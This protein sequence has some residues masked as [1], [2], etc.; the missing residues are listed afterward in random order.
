M[1]SSRL[2]WLGVV[3]LLFVSSGT[4]TLGGEPG[5]A[6]VTR[7][8]SA[9]RK[10]VIAPA[11]IRFEGALEHRLQVAA[12]W[13]D[14]AAREAASRY[15]GRGLDLV[16]FP[17]FALQSGREP[18]AADQAVTIEGPVQD[19]VGGKARELHT[20]IVMPMTLRET[21]PTPGAKPRLSN[22]AV[23]FDRGGKV[24]GIFRKVHPI[25]DD[26][27]V[28]EGGVAPGDSYPVF[29][30]DFGKL[31]ILI[32]WDMSYEEA[33]DALAAGGAEIVAVPTASPQN[34]QPSAQ[35]R[36]HHYYVVNSAPRDNATVFDPIGR[37]V[38]Q[39]TTAPGVVVQKVD[40]AYAILHWS[41]TLHN[42]QAF[43]DRYG[44]KAG[45][46]YSEREDTGIF[47]SNDPQLPIGTMVR[48]L[49][50]KEMPDLIAA[51]EAARRRV[52]AK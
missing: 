45:Y 50:L 43:T 24:A 48:E 20:W 34:V 32:C 30:C 33:W 47:W 8:N 22:A 39:Q 40:L 18:T 9:P 23:L 15:E 36:R 28:F 10:V 16:V 52:S 5:R 12:D 19:V 2:S 26:R 51:Q 35:A 1:K 29:Q 31:G 17:E 46:N 42:G 25:A 27:G 13:I 41:E 21:A 49:G 4:I 3:G 44:A 38:A 7:S 11:V 6:F 37:V 14:H